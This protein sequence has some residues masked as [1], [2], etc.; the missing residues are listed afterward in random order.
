MDDNTSSFVGLHRDDSGYGS[1][2]LNH[3]YLSPHHTSSN[4]YSYQHP[5]HSHIPYG[6]NSFHMY[7]Q[8]VGNNNIYNSM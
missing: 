1:P 7:D 8:L 6:N 3:D 4:Y 5:Y 2:V